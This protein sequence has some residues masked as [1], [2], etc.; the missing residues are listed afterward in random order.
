MK[1][2]FTSL[3]FFLSAVCLLHA[4]DSANG[5]EDARSFSDSLAAVKMEGKWGFI[6]KAGKEVISFQYDKTGNRAF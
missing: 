2:C 4:Q 3:I 5:W 6:D 1:K